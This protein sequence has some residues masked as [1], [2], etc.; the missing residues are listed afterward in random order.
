[1]KSPFTLQTIAVET[2][3]SAGSPRLCWL[4]LAIAFGVLGF[5]WLLV[6]P[7]V[8]RHPT[9]AQHIE[10]QEERGID[11][12]AMFYSEHEIIRPIAHRIE[13]LQE[14]HGKSFWSR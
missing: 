2:P 10:D 9:V 7:A 6:L 13:R 11:P 14:T 3:V 5:V 1:M 4:K 8:G 12:S